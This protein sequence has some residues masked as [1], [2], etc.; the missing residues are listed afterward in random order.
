MRELWK[1]LGRLN[2]ISL[3]IV[4]VVLAAALGV[5]IVK[6]PVAGLIIAAGTIALTAFCIWFFFRD[7]VRNNRLRE[8]GQVT[9]ATILE[10]GETGITVQGDY[11]LAELRLRVEP[12]GGEP[13]EATTRCLMN[14]F[15]IPD[16]SP[17]AVSRCLST[18][19]TAGRSRSRRRRPRD[20]QPDGHDRR[21]GG[22]GAAQ[23]RRPSAPSR[24]HLVDPRLAGGVLSR[25]RWGVAGPR[26]RAAR[27]SSRA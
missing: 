22:R 7:E 27:S 18:P 19:R 11:P 13:H 10:V 24:S 3:I 6:E 23:H 1:R 8:R 25:L 21:R 26:K 9:E 5:I 4:A 15:E 17:A 2:Q 14:R 20:R 16:T 12:A